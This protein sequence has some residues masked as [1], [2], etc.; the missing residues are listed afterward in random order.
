MKPKIKT[1]Y[2]LAVILFLL[3]C[4]IASAQQK[5]TVVVNADLGTVKISKYIYGQFAEDLGRGIYGGVWVGPNSDIPNIDGFRK[6]VV[7]AL[8]KIDV[9]DVRWPGGCFAD[10]Y[11][12]KDGIGPR[13][14]RPKRVNMWGNVI[15]DNS[16][17]TAEFLEFCKLIGAD[18]YLAGNV[19]SGTEQ[20]MEQ[21]VE[22]LTYPGGTTLSDLRKKNGHPAPYHIKFWGV[23][24]ESWGCGGNMTPEFY[25]DQYKRYTTYLP[26]YGGNHLFK[27]ASGPNG[28]DYHWTQVMMKDVGRRMNGLSLHYYTIAG[29]SWSNKGPSTNFSEKL[30]FD[31]LKKAN[32]MD[33]IVSRHSSIMDQYDPHKHVA[34]VVDEWGIW[35]DPLP[36]T[37]PGFLE[38]QNSM[39]DAL[40]AST[41]L[42]IFNKHAA[43]VRMA[44]IA[45]MVNVLQAM[46]LTKG[47][48]MVLTPTYYVFDMYKV[49]MNATYLPISIHS[50]NYTFD[51]DSLPAI[52]A[53]ASKDSTGKVHITMSNIDPSKKQTVVIDL[54][55][56]NLH[57]VHD[58]RILTAK[59]FDSVNTFKNPNNV[60]PE[61]FHNARL[62]DGKLTVEMPSK[63]IVSLELQ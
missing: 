20:E 25:A 42:D 16:F 55:G 35:T 21:W 9:P 56:I 32:R 61:P 45:Q 6:D 58:G 40:V 50:A 60:K 13:K 15:D 54:R 4:Q 44:N 46:I 48:Q 14:D 26:N 11:H 1:S 49:H 24:N 29:P 18:P 28:P 23:G 43:R 59:S 12:W 51:G 30:Y 36:G 47:K 39:R 52:S 33:E 63:S 34:L 17:G 10:Q 53:T 41:T 57:S 3:A 27:I 5:D 22:Y 2:I 37:N 38:Q 31:A 19:G 8:K 7:E 62:K